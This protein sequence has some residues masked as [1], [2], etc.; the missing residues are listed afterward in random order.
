M[1]T[2]TMYVLLNNYHFSQRTQLNF[3]NLAFLWHSMKQRANVM[4]KTLSCGL[5]LPCS[6][7]ADCLLDFQVVVFVLLGVG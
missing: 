6:C 5:L 3:A 7:G 1:L 4:G 2:C